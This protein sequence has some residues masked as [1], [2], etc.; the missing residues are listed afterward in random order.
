[1][2]QCTQDFFEFE[3]HFSRGV[4]ARFD[5][6]TMTSDGGALLLRQTNRRL[7]LL[8]RLAACFDD[9]RSP[10]L[11]SH[12]VQE[13]VS[14]RVY[15]LTLG[16]ED[17]NDHDQLREDPLLAV[18]SGKRH[19]GE[20]T[21][22]GKSTLNRLELST[23]QPSRYKKIHCRAEAVDELLSTVFVEAH[24]APPERV[25]LD[26]DVTDLPLYGHQEGR[27]FH[28]Y[29]DEY[30]YLPLYI[31]AGEHLLCARLRT[32]DQDA[33][34]GSLEEV[35]RIVGQLR[36]AWPEVEIILRADSG[37]CREELMKWCEGHGVGYV[38]GFARNDKLRRIIAAEMEEATRQQAATGKPAR[39]FTEFLYQTTTGSWSRARRMVAK[40]EQ[41][42]GKEN[43]RYVVTNLSTDEWPARRL[44]EDLYC[45]RGEMEN[46]I[47]EQLSLFATR[48]SAETMR[49]NQ[50]RLYFSAMAYVLMH[51]LRRLGLKGTEL[52][53]A[54]ATTIRLRLLKIGAQIRVTARR[55]W[56]SLASSYPLQPLFAQV[57]TALR[58]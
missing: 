33:S 42:E 32:A 39:V 9:Q 13:L 49:A 58:C 30:C 5:G 50:V 4:V 57:W 26:L 43:P 10:W 17:L 56:L 20:E 44:Y 29:Y 53:R 28:G 22:A 40:A 8:S 38:F 55:V 3:A 27:F 2:T 37:F 21:L 24:D 15:G 6:G 36:A 54:Q 34:A 19:L 14:Q 16:Y 45:E 31:F 51:G 35:V 46:R 1:M 7:N 25:V 47:K 41:I 23:E 52:A 12:S 48:V 18:L 11:I